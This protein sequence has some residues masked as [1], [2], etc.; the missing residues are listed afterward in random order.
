MDKNRTSL[1]AALTTAFFAPLPL[2]AK[3]DEPRLPASP[4]EIASWFKSVLYWFGER[5]ESLLVLAF[6]AL[7]SLLLAVITALIFKFIFRKLPGRKSTG[8]RALL[9]EKLPIPI[10][11]AVF[12]LGLFASAVRLIESLSSGARNVTTRLMWAIFAFA[13]LWSIFR[14]I[15]VLDGVLKKM[16]GK[17]KGNLNI[18]LVNMI[19][20][21]LKAVIAVIALLFIFQNILGLNVTTLLAGAGVAGLAI[22]FAA[23]NTIANF[24]SSIMV[25]MDK[26]FAVGDRVRINNIDGT[27]EEVGLRSTRIR[28]LDGN[29]FALPNSMVADNAIE[30]VS[31]RPSLKY[32]FDIT[33]TYSTTPE[34][35]KQAV[36]ILHDILDHR[37]E[38]DPKQPPWIHF[39]EFR[40][41]SLAINV[42][43]WFGSGNWADFLKSRHEIN[44]EVLEK[45]NAAGLNFAFPTS[46][47]YLAGVKQEPVI[48]NKES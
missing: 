39:G 43:C 15:G 12:V 25:I 4:D 7:G 18:L 14:S 24:F 42:V 29:L 34:Q 11:T 32:N 8:A 46:T 20:K 13:V 16:I 37:P 38:L 27:V 17:D 5:R 31:R 22:A 35:M 19:R 28:A 3:T 9:A 30:N 41:W 1:L 6:G 2:L 40:D 47:N 33:L 21:T 36:A 48:I 10:G 44:L 45:F 26:P 23:Q